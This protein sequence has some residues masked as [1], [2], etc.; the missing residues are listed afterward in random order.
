[1]TIADISTPLNRA[2][3]MAPIMS[4]FAAGTALG[5]AIGGIMADHIGISETFYL[6]GCSYLALTLVNRGLLEETKVKPTTFPW[7]DVHK[8][9]NGQKENKETI[10][11]AFQNAIGQW[12]ELM[13]D[14]RVRGVVA[15]NGFYWFALSGSQMTLLPLLLTDPTGLALSATSV[16]KVYM[17]MSLV[18]VMC[19]PTLAK[20]ADK[21]GKEKAILFGCALISSS[22]ATLPFCTDTNH[23]A[24]TLGLWSLGSTMLSTAPV[25]YVSDVV[26]AE[27]R[28]QGIALLRTAGDV[29]FL[30]G[31]A[32]TGAFADWMGNLDVAM[33]SSAGLL[34]SA[35]GWF[36]ARCFLEKKLEQQN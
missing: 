12:S 6:V 24:V 21:M 13:S 11:D 36:A 9:Q 31:A 22:M 10:A 32:G 29:G 28:A 17:G 33:Q 27:K 20:F 5:P 8:R 26:H 35:T 19:N 4:A 25:A 7:N 18:Q 2:S 34:V 14:V 30:L 23:V 1:M 15:M 3:T 16:G